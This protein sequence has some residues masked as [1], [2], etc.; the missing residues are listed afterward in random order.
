MSIEANNYIA[1]HY[2][3]REMMSKLYYQILAYREKNDHSPLRTKEIK[4]R[5]RE[6]IYQFDYAEYPEKE[7]AIL[8]HLRAYVYKNFPN[9]IYRLK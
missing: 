1:K 4:T 6:L 3:T 2:I 5:L 8:V 9:Y 7:K